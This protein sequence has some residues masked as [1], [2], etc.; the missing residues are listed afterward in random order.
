MR[1]VAVVLVV[2]FSAAGCVYSTNDR[3]SDLAN[4]TPTVPP[5][6]VADVTPVPT[7]GE[8]TPDQDDGAPSSPAGEPGWV[9]IT[10]VA[11]SLN[12][13]SGPGTENGVVAQAE[14]GTVLPTTGE[15]ARDGGARW[16]EVVLE[17]EALG[18]VHG[19][20][21]ERVQEPTPT[22]LSTPTPLATPTPAASGGHLVVDAPLG[23]R[24][25]SEP[26]VNGDVIRTIADG[27]R[28]SPTGE[29][30]EGGAGRLWVEIVSEEDTG[31]V[32]LAFLRTP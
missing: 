5:T 26:S 9:V 6:S 29:S 25:R 18:W 32:A 14:L 2:L 28:V 12:V 11:G 22:P 19:D 15:R 31:W 4:A 3:A 30:A 27:S 10:G 21:V 23:L 20:F 13:R 17:D 7:P 16:L 1:L 8:G 24:M